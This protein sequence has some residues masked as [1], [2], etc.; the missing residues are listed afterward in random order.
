MS[1][2][3]AKLVWLGFANI[4]DRPYL[5]QD[6]IRPWINVLD[7][8]DELTPNSYTLPRGNSRWSRLFMHKVERSIGDRRR[9]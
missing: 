5:E 6:E 7:Q 3:A 2:S 1:S 4:G 9:R 8:R